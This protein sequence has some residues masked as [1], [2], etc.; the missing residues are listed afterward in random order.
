MNKSGGLHKIRTEKG[1]GLALF[2]VVGKFVD[3]LNF[4]PCSIPGV[5]PEEW[6]R[7]FSPPPVG[8]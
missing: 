5:A 4:G 1:E 3:Y 2:E 8:V 7:S 6:V